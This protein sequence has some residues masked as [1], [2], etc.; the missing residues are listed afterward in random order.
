MVGR[1]EEVQFFNRFISNMLAM[2][3]LSS[4][5]V[6]PHRLRHGVFFFNQCLSKRAAHPRDAHARCRVSYI[7]PS[8][9]NES[10]GVGEFWGPRLAFC[11]VFIGAITI[12][13]N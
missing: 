7:L 2:R 9:S 3:I 12:L 4:A 13:L 5:E 6:L 11:M 8:N 10:Y 1:N